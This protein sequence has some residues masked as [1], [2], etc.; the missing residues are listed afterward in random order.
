MR[1]ITAYANN[2]FTDSYPKIILLDFQTP[3]KCSAVH[4]TTLTFS[5][6]LMKEI[7][8]LCITP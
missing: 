4:N 1:Q 5:A 3:S 2:M 8:K 6:R 7:I